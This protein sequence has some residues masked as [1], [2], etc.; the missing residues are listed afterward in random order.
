MAEVKLGRTAFSQG[1]VAMKPYAAWDPLAQV[2]LPAEGN[3]L[4]VISR[5]FD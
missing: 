5:D 2:G 1:T 4:P 3:A